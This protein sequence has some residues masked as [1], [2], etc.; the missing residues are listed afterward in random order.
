MSHPP[1]RVD[2]DFGGSPHLAQNLANSITAKIKVNQ[3][4]VRKLMEHS[5]SRSKLT[6]IQPDSISCDPDVVL[7][8]AELHVARSRCLAAGDSQELALPLLC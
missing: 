8:A 5:V 2:L 4:N 6:L 7:G 3:A 1:C